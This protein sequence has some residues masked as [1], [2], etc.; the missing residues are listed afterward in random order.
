M[1]DMETKAPANKV[2]R[3]GPDGAVHVLGRALTTQLPPGL[4][5]PWAAPRLTWT[6]PPGWWT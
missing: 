5:G 2:T 1:V 4:C 6:H 3:L